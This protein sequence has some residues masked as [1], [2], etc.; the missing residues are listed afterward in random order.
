MNSFDK[1]GSFLGSQ[2][3]QRSSHR[4]VLDRVGVYNPKIVVTKIVSSF[5]DYPRSAAKIYWRIFLVEAGGPCQ[6]KGQGTNR[7]PHS[8]A[9]EYFIHLRLLFLWISMDWTMAYLWSQW[10]KYRTNEYLKMFVNILIIQLIPLN[11]LSKH[12]FYYKKSLL[13]IV[14]SFP[15]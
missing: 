10:W 15:L 14:P 1:I 4:I 5:L 11:Y 3:N 6:F 9:T 2:W 7:Q 13:T 12:L 8:T